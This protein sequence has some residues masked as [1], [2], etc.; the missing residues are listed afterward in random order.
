[1]GA[2]R[3]GVDHRRRWHRDRD[4]RN[5]TQPDAIQNAMTAAFDKY[6]ALHEGSNADYIPALAKVDPNL[7]GIAIVTTDEGP[8]SEDVFW[9]FIGANGSGCAVPGGAVGDAV[10]DRLKRLPGVDYEAVIIAMGSADNASFEVWKRPAPA[11]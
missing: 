5:A 2:R 11:A 9:L 1:V 4:R 10:F 6:K 7:Y 3:H 8:W